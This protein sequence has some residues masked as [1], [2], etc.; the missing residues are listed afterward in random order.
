MDIRQVDG[1]TALYI[2]AFNG[3][4]DMLKL[5][6][7]YKVYIIKKGKKEVSPFFFLSFFL[8]Q[9][10]KKKGKFESPTQRWYVSTRS[11]RSK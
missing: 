7:S 8:I 11:R 6:H 2:A 4:E 10:F 3:F 9:E 5:L 1:S